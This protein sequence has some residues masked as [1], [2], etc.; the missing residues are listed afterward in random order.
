MQ[1]VTQYINHINTLPIS[2][3]E[4][5][6]G[7][8]LALLLTG[9]GFIILIALI[10]SLI[11]DFG[12]NISNRTETTQTYATMSFVLAGILA[13]L[14]LNRLGYINQTGLLFVGLLTFG[15]LFG[16]EPFRLIW[17]PTLFFLAIP[18]LIASFV[19]HPAA[20]FGVVFASI[21]AF[22]FHVFRADTFGFNI[23]G[24]AGLFGVAFVSWLSANSLDSALQQLY[25]MNRELDQ[26]VVERTQELSAALIREKTEAKKNE[27]ILESLAD[28]VLVFD[29]NSVTVSANP[30][31]QQLLGRE[32]TTLINRTVY[33]L[34]EAQL[35][36]ENR[37][38]LLEQFNLSK[39]QPVNF[40][41]DW[42]EKTFAISLATIQPDEG[43]PISGSVAVIRDFTREAAIDRMKSD[44]ISIASH[45]LRTPLTALKGYIDL[46][47]M[48]ATESL[49]EKQR[50]YLEI[51]K[52]NADR[53]QDLVTD[54]LNSSQ[55]ETGQIQLNDRTIELPAIVDA[56][57]HELQGEVAQR[58]LWVKAEI[59]DD[60]PPVHADKERI[61]QVLYNL[62]SNA[63]KYTAEGGITV[64]LS[65]ENGFVITEIKDTGYGIA[66][67]E[68]EKIFSR[69]FRS[70]DSTGSPPI[71]YGF[72]VKYHLL[73]D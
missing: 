36:E 12:V 57:L 42:Q 55:L 16:I 68:Q 61:I 15:I 53:L 13:L 25:A 51:M 56:V 4:K 54:L 1:A 39:K 48:T 58:N 41:I 3:D 71:R 45:E 32:P 70:S 60:I 67:T 38:M 8:L 35:T 52:Q 28:G 43:T 22:L 18:I 49:N 44:F 9:M 73:I 7:R 50:T 19:I 46:L 33:D 62:I 20:S 63:Y 40:K 30:A 65:Q 69:F 37:G 34:L 11:S 29:E 27:A 10:G 6:R 64:R 17:G 31:I 72:R 26:H 23:T 24:S 2:N 47:Q 59:P 21:L 14:W 66:H 5:R